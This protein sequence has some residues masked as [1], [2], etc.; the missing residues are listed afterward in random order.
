MDMNKKDGHQKGSNKNIKIE[1]KMQGDM[2]QS[3]ENVYKHISL[4]K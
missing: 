1:R 2:Q 3:C 4:Q